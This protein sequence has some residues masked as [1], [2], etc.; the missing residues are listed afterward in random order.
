MP[1]LISA[2]DSLHRSLKRP[3][4]NIYSMSNL[5]SFERFVDSSIEKLC[6]QLEKLYAESAHPQQCDLSFWLQAFVFDTLG[7]LTFSQPYGFVEQGK[8]I[9]RIMGD[10]W[11]HFEKVSLIGQMPWI[12][13]FL[14]INPLLSKLR[15][16]PMSPIA[17]FSLA[18]IQE[19][20]MRGEQGVS[21]VNDRDLLSRF[22]AAQAQNPGTPPFAIF[23]W[24][25]GNIT[26]GSDTTATVLRSLIYYLLKNSVTLQTLLSEITAA[27]RA[28]L[29]SNPPMWKETQNLRYLNACVMEA[30]R[31]HAPVGLH[32]ERVVPKEGATLCGK[33][34][35]GGT[36]VGINAWVV[37]RDT[38]TFGDD[39]DAWRP[40]RWIDCIEEQRARMDK[41]IFTVSIAPIF[42]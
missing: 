7:E 18:R 15:L 12:D 4:S 24:I 33:H 1:G 27:R 28:G 21:E 3:I 6:A 11:S 36:V 41:A 29:L 23:A 19:R 26:A 22:L 17:K 32:L 34:I 8:D 20:K 16:Q 35:R 25:A 14:R 30:Q 37:H 2:K 10:I 31:V 42:K 40:E 13:T 5:V 9:E 39:V 38:R